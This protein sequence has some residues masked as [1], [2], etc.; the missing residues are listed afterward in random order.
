MMQVDKDYH[1]NLTTAEVDRILDALLNA[2]DARADDHAAS[3]PTTSRSAT[4]SPNGWTLAAYERDGGYEA[5]RSALT[6]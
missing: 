2:A 5:A 3:A 6:R 1:E 4:A